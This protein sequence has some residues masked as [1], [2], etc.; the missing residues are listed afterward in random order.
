MAERSTVAGKFNRIMLAVACG[1]AVLVCSILIPQHYLTQR[2]ALLDR[3]A[4]M[5]KAE[6][7]LAEALYYGQ[8]DELQPALNDLLNL[9]GIGQIALFDRSGDA[10]LRYPS[11][12]HETQS[13]ETAPTP[14]TFERLRKDAAPLQPSL[15]SRSN[16]AGQGRLLEFTLPVFSALNP[17][18]DTV[19]PDKYARASLAITSADSLHVVGYTNLSISRPEL[20]RQTVSYASLVC[21]SAS[22]FVLF[23][24]LIARR[25]TGQ[26][27]AP[28][29]RLAKIAEDVSSGKVDGEIRLKG[30]GEVKQISGLLNTIMHDLAAYKSKMDVDHQLLS[31]KVEERNAQLSKRNHELSQAINEVNQTKDQ[32][33]KLA[34]FDSLTALPNRRLFT[35]QLNLLLR[36]SK[37]HDTLLALLFL[38]LDNFKRINDSL[39][40]AAG[41][42][43]LR[44]V[45]MR[46]TDCVREGDVVAHNVDSERIDVSRLGGDEFTVVLN[47]LSEAEEAGR[48]AER[49]LTEL[50]KPMIIEGHELIITPSIGIA[51]SPTDSETVEGLLKNADT[52]MYFAKS[53]GKNNYV[54]YASTMS[55]TGV[56]R[57]KLETELRKAMNAGE[58]I[59]HYQPQVDIHTGSIVGAE[60]LLRW[61]HPDL[62]LVPPFKFIP[63]AEEMGLIG[64]LGDWCLN[65]ACRQLRRFHKQGLDLPKISVNVSSLQFTP[66]F[67]DQVAFTLAQ[68]GVDARCI[69]LELTEGLMMNN[70]RSTIDT[71]VALKQLGV[72]LS[73]DDFG[74]GYSSLSYLSQFPLDE[75]KIDRSFVTGFDKSDH[76][77]SLVIAIIAMARSMNL[78]LVAE[79]VETQEQ[80][81][82]L[83][84]H[85]VSVIQG[86]LFSKPVPADDLAQLLT[87]N[88]YLLQMDHLNRDS[89]SETA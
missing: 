87:P 14:P 31:L 89:R 19:Q 36:L 43:M 50:S 49:I 30:D 7:Q 82:F 8:F 11:L 68:T 69:E 58:L 54:F 40:H 53:T 12:D 55:A 24:W 66:D 88:Q 42:L 21:G 62:G 29:A 75:L 6:P 86:Y 51:V 4:W 39:G 77:A 70:T 26:I 48:V 81:H 57:L 44:E 20:L 15:I 17:A 56:D 65:Q 80:Y 73:I 5:V 23:S 25:T 16:P 83:K 63:M 79:G 72:S 61:E 74:T 33:R 37:R 18:L 41:D 76:D 22:I 85:E 35:E 84:K 67:A 45:A 32:L 3:L 38:D 47:E 10:L 59:L 71:L 78:S 13:S 64:E 46:L 27:T 52:A 2:Q 34:Y 60:A 1:A 28:L 9:K